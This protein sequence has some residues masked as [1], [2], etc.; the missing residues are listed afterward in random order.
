GFFR[1]LHSGFIALGEAG[2]YQIIG[3]IK[4]VQPG[5]ILANLNTA[6]MAVHIAKAA[7]IHEDVEA[8]ALASREGAQQL[9]VFAAM[10]G[11]QSDDLVP[12]AGGERFNFLT[13]LPISIMRVLVEQ[14]GG[15][16][17]L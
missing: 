13:N 5:K 7:D 6:A 9:I 16:F 8:K 15:E 12:A 17:D 14:S 2:G 4:A 3:R 11:A 1:P 10:F